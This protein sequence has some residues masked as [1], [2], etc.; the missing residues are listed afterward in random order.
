MTENSD[1]KLSEVAR[2]IV[3]PSGIVTSMFPKVNKRAKACG[4]RYDRWQQGLLTL[5]LGRRTDGTFAASVGGVVLSICRQTGKTFTVSS[6]VVILCT[7]IPNL[8]VIWTAHHNR[9]NSNTFD[10]VRTLVRNPALIG[11]LDHSGRTDG[12]RGGNGM[13]EITFANGSKILFGA[14]AQGFARGNDAV[15]IIVFDEAQILTEQAISDMVPATNTSP[16]A[17]VLY[18]GTPPRPADPGEAFTER[19]RQALAGE[20]D[21]LYVE[22]SAD[23]DADSDDRAQWRKAN[24]SFPRRTSE[25]SMLRMQRQLGKDSFRREAL[26]IWDETT[27]SQAINPEQWAKAAT[28][29]PNIKGLIGYALDMKPD[30]SSLAIGGA[31]NH[32]DGTAHIELRRFE[33]TQSK[34]TQWAVD[35]IADHW[36]RTASVVIDSQSPAMSL[37][38]DLKARHVK[39]IVTNYSDMGRACGKFL[40]MLRDGKL[41]HLPDDKAPAL[42]TA[43]ANATTRSIGKSGAVGW[44]PMGSDIDISPLVACTLA[45]YGTTITKRDPDRVQEVMIG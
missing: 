42:A 1:P 25:T 30:R 44:N 6:L 29:T 5:I 7:L 32:R 26:G 28:G 11:Y 34:G 18:I 37:L 16:N 3:M 19:R 21:M 13:Q 36:P 8:T 39:V 40:D 12:V 22:F 15:D 23:R 45:L 43:V 31:V 38:A 10:H 9:T 27:T 33:A 14:R 4:I 24:P 20:D 17:L 35:Y 41:T 2:H